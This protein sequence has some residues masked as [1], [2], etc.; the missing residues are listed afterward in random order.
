MNDSI[1]N[2]LLLNYEKQAEK[3]DRFLQGDIIPILLG[4]YGEVGGVMATS[5]KYRREKKAYVGYKDAVEEEFGDAFWY[6]SALCR[7]LGISIENV[8]KNYGSPCKV[9]DEIVPY[10]ELY[11]CGSK[12][13]VDSAL[14]NLGCV[15][16]RLLEENKN[17]DGLREIIPYFALSF[18]NAIELT[19]LDFYK[20]V[21]SNLNKTL[22]RFAPLGQHVL[23]DFDAQFPVDEQLPWH[24]EIQITQRKS[25]QSYLKWNDVFIGDPLTDNIKNPDGYRFHDVFHMAFAAVLHWSPTFRSLIKHKRKSDPATD[26]EQ[27]GGRAIVVEE[28]L[29]AWLFSYAQSLDNFEGHDSVSFDVLKT[30]QKF[31]QGYEVE[32]CPLKLWEEAILQ[33]YSVFRKVKENEGGLVIGDRKNRKIFYRQL[34]EKNES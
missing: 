25:G 16:A 19:E 11:E 6:F 12:S 18:R 7:R 15:T 27:D 17:L 10:L 8:F 1:G 4:L 34:E 9:E 23:D 22:G 29:T 13:D 21:Q 28:G 20:V 2:E 24:F 32:K 31:V 3:T 5:K 30:I 26:M 14:I 33:G